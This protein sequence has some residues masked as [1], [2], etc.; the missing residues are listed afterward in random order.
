MIH[1]VQMITV[2]PGNSEY[3]VFH[4][5]RPDGRGQLTEGETIQSATVSA[6]V[7]G[8]VTSVSGLVSEVAPYDSTAVRYKIDPAGAELVSG[9]VVTLTFEAVTSN[10]QTLTDLLDVRIN[11]R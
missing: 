3:R 2:P 1:P 8:A 4:F 9:A 6:A 11:N 5:T 7:Y 10:G